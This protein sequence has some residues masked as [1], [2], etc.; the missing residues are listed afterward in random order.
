MSKASEWAALEKHMRFQIS[1]RQ[2][3]RA[4]EAGGVILTSYNSA[5]N[6]SGQLA[7]TASE[8]LALARWLVDTFGEP[9]SAAKPA[10]EAS[11]P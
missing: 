5:G 7:L 11:A 4:V 3:A 8:A 2:E 1:D 6:T 10:S 9:A